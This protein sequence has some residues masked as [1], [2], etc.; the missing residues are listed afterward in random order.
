[1]SAYYDEVVEELG[2]EINP[3]LV[4][5]DLFAF[6]DGTATY[7]YPDAAIEL[8]QLWHIG[9]P[10]LEVSEQTVEAYSQ[11]WRSAEGTPKA[12]LTKKEASRTVRIYPI[13]DTTSSAL[14]PLATQPLG[15]DF[16]ANSGV[17]MFSDSRESGLSEMLGCYI[18]FRV[19]Y[20]EFVRPSGHQD[21]EWA[22]LLK[23]IA[24]V[25]Y[26]LGVRRDVHRRMTLNE[27]SGKEGENG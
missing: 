5:I 13:P 21:I 7:N 1:V 14:A 18:A 9:N 24:Q 6:A 20:K 3:P 12:R 17:A 16:P 26:V 15:E 4:E 22:A 25:F 23:E 27:L 10:L 19:L 11:T 2:K 8:L